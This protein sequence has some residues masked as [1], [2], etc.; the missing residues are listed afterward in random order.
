MGDRDKLP[1]NKLPNQ[2]PVGGVDAFLKKLAGMSTVRPVGARGRMIFALDATAS[3][4]P[5]WDQA[6]EIQAEM[7]TEAGSLGG[8]DIQLVYYRGFGEFEASPWLGASAELTRRMTGVLCL[9]GRTQIGRVL[10]HAIAE[11]KRQ[12]V[13]ALVFVGDCMEESIDELCDMAGQLG[14]LGLP[15]FLFHEGRDRIA[16]DAFQQM[17]RLS[18]GACCPFDAGSAKQLRELL[19]AVAAYA[20]GG[21]QALENFSRHAGSQVLLLA[22]QLDR[23]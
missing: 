5:T 9:G 15:M 19:R 22:R 10:R 2:A 11:T 20:A 4:Q 17:A 1:D 6:C 14:V 7:F 21:R 12:R 8:L 23:K 3:R 13:N 18:G 16:A